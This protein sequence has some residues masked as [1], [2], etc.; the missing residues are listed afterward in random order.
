MCVC[1]KDLSVISFILIP[2]PCLVEENLEQCVV[3]GGKTGLE[4]VSILFLR[5]WS[6]TWIK[7]M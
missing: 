2:P 5:L 3:A 6:N 1:V 4:F 7:A